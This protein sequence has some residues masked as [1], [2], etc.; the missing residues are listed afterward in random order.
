MLAGRTIV[1]K[2]NIAVGGLPTTAGLPD[3]A[4]VNTGNDL[5]SPIDA[6]VVSRIL[7]AGA[8]IKGTSTCESY[9][10]SPL[11][12]TSATG[13]VHNP[14][15]HGYTTGGS[16]S[17]S[18]ALVAAHQLG[19][20][21]FGDTVEMAL[22]SDQ[23]GSVRMPASFNGL[24]G[25]KP[26]HGLVPYTGASCMATMIDYLGPI[27]ATLDDLALLLEV[28][29]GWDGFDPRMTPETPLRSAVK[30]YS[31]L[32]AAAREKKQTGLR[33][34]LL[35]ESFTMAGVT[36][37]VR[38]LIIRHATDFFTRAGAT[39]TEV[40]VPMHTQGPAIWTAATRPSVA[41]ALCGGQPLGHLAYQSPHAESK[42]PPTQETYD[43]LTKL[44]P[45]VVNI[46]FNEQYSREYAPA[47]LAAKAH[48]LAFQLREAY[49]A[50]LNNVDVLVAPCTPCP[51]MPHP[52]SLD[53]AGRP[54]SVLQ[55][56]G[57]AVGV[58]SNTCAF[59]VTG[60]PALSVPCG[61][62]LAPGTD[63]PMP[64]GMQII[65]RRWEDDAVIAAA[66]VFER[67]RV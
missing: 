19:G 32:L 47:G 34:G 65:G 5:L 61:E 8:V 16:S 31:K 49:D 35:K 41:S 55:R 66:A 36:D 3:S 54:L 6:V 44:N 21:K 26:T 20:G 14:R 42:W 28:M 10:A 63:V 58:T 52:A 27:T 50:V 45:G 40:S 25:L 7:A 37:A 23:A 22:G 53:G 13:P 9:C 29:A 59:N 56:L 51:A 67:G 60:H 15:L 39:V 24:Y 30:P 48:R 64:V 38:D 17:G 1:I 4:F 12:F 46:M 11:S 62:V 57:T 2:D 33:V 18:A 43:S